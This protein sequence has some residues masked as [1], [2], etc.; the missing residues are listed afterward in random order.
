VL[1]V[2][3]N[4][5]SAEMLAKL[6]KRSGH[7]VRTAYSGPM[8]LEAAAQL[9]DVV[10]LDIGLPGING[11][12]VARRLRLLPDLENLKIVAMTGYGQDADRQLA[13][14]AGFDSH[15]TKPVDFL[16]VRDL[17]ARLFAS[18]GSSTDHP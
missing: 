16:E 14:E 9:P 17:L 11:Y 15:L 12:E 4:E 18:P 8:A 2:D 7:G 1:V 5:D 13:R 6:L 10:L 3:D